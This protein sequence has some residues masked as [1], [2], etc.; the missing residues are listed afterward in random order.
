[1]AGN[2]DKAL[3]NHNA[4]RAQHEALRTAN[5]IDELG[6][7]QLRYATNDVGHNVRH[8]GQAVLLEGGSHEGPSGVVANLLK[9]VDECDEHDSASQMSALVPMICAGVAKMALKFQ[10]KW[11][12]SRLQRKS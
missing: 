10:R 9:R 3:T 11:D 2:G 1:M 5:H 4:H 7:W 6:E 12:I 8:G